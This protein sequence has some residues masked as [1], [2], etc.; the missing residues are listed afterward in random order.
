MKEIELNSINKKYLDI[1]DMLQKK[2]NTDIKYDVYNSFPLKI[3]S[4]DYGYIKLADGSITKMFVATSEVDE[5]KCN[6]LYFSS[7][8]LNWSY[9]DFPIVEAT[10]SYNKMI[11]HNG[12]VY[13]IFDNMLR[14][15]Y[16]FDLNVSTMQEATIDGDVYDIIMAK[17][18][19]YVLAYNGFYTISDDDQLTNFISISEDF[20]FERFIP[21][22]SNELIIMG[23]AEEYPVFIIYDENGPH[24][25]F[26]MTA[27]K[28][29]TAIS[30][31]DNIYCYTDD[32]R[33]ITVYKTSVVDKSSFVEYAGY[34][35][36]GEVYYYRSNFW[37]AY[38]DYDNDQLYTYIAKSSNGLDFDVDVRIPHLTE[39]DGKFAIASDES[40]N[41]VICI[42][43]GDTY[44]LIPSI[45]YFSY[46]IPVIYKNNS[47]HVPSN[48]EITISDFNDIDNFKKYNITVYACDIN[49]KV[50]ENNV[51]YD[52]SPKVIDG[53][54]FFKIKEIE[55]DDPNSLGICLYVMI[56][57]IKDVC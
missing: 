49:G 56:Y 19:L 20:P 25:V 13:V 57:G 44:T 28:L 38:M 14:R 24:A 36:T 43:A 41:N 26:C 50:I 42:G 17:N 31:K 54:I 55:Y 9:I 8:G 4:I 29:Q 12:S 16:D 33:I 21:S 32:R 1:A 27:C 5:Y 2:P 15:L 48:R 3:E 45:N 39:N 7:D 47:I 18:K 22:T 6:S 11:I 35:W 40:M 30:Y 53:N 23:Y 51:K 37:I 34:N 52:I 46:G 10:T